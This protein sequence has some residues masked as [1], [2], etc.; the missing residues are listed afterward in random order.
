MSPSIDRLLDSLRG[1]KVEVEGNEVVLD[2][3]NAVIIDIQP[4]WRNQFLSILTDPNI[5]YILLLIGV[6]GVLLEFYS[7][8]ALYPGVIGH[9]PILAGYSLHLLPVSF[10][11]LAYWYWVLS[12]WL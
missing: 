5:T 1:L 2:T 4:N 8:G 6:Y 7:P 11:V 3:K 12:F 9:M 10:A